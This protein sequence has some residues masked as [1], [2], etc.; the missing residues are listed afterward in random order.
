MGLN[1]I[2]VKM[3]FYW[4]EEI[5]KKKEKSLGAPISIRVTLVRA[6]MASVS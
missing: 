1:R 5:K 2:E 3:W 4:F 6:S